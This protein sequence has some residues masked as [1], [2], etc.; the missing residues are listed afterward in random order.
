MRILILS[1][2]DKP[3]CEVYMDNVNLVYEKEV[4]LS[5]KESIISKILKDNIDTSPYTGVRNVTGKLRVKTANWLD[6]HFNGSINCEQV[7]N[8]TRGK[9]YDVVRV[10]GLGDCEDV[11][12]IDDS[13][14][15]QTLADFFF[16]EI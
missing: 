1:L 4:R 13:G 9:I 16:E 11:T 12:I 3:E 6:G 10:E 5:Q 7:R 2:L 14:N 8:I 15:E